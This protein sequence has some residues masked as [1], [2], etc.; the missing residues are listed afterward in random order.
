MRARKRGFALIVSLLVIGSLGCN[1]ISHTKVEESS[2]EGLDRALLDRA[3]T[4]DAESQ[5]RVG[6][7]YE[8]GEGTEI[9]RDRARA[10]YALSA[11]QGNPRGQSA[12]GRLLVNAEGGEVRL[13]EGLRF[14]ELSA[15]QGEASAW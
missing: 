13:S 10:W 14:I 4:G 9:D 6:A 1:R 7:A 3:E 5:F 11:E 15:E 12:L 2:G 8:W